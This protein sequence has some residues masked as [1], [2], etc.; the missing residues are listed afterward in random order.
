L[1]Q[2]LCCQQTND[3]CNTKTILEAA[4]L[5]TEILN[6][7]PHDKKPKKDLYGGAYGQWL[8]VQKAIRTAKAEAAQDTWQYTPSQRAWWE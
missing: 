7:K 4:T 2:S 5:S 6:I 8:S 3:S 1:R